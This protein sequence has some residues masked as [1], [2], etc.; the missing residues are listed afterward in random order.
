MEHAMPET[1]SKFTA[2]TIDLRGDGRILLYPR[3]AKGTYQARI[4]VPNSTGFVIKTTKTNRLH[5]ATAF[6]VSLY[7]ELYHHVK[8]GGALK[9]SPTYKAVYEEWILYEKRRGITDTVNRYS[10]PFFAKDPIDR[11]NEARLTD[12]W[13]HRRSTFL[14]RRASNNTLLRECT[15]MNGLFRY[16]KAK[17]YI[18]FIPELN[19]LEIAPEKTRRPT[20]TEREWRII[21]RHMREW[22]KLLTSK[23]V[24]H[25]PVHIRDRVIAINYFLIL[26][27][28]GIRVGEAR[29]LRW[30]DVRTSKD[31]F[32][33]IVVKGKT[34]EREVVAQKGT[35]T[36]FDRI[37]QYTGNQD[38]VF[39]HP[40]GEPIGSL[41]KAFASLLESAKVPK[42]ARTIY[43]LRHLYATFR[44]QHG[45]NPYLLAKN[46][47]TSVEMIEKHY[48]HIINSDMAE[49]ITKLR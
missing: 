31:G 18:T 23:T 41:K 26:A 2:Q 34:G 42:G 46:M 11:I 15:Y 28:T 38:L 48:G 10:V 30:R 7:D 13:L 20:F 39:C 40:D 47:G 49:Q 6:A 21:T 44:L 37:K 32:T 14:K 27:N 17:G 43:S 25:N 22:L 35:A 33:I 36:Y 3:G 4:K 1:V 5:E 12:F 24:H 9:S 19:P 45:T 29:T 8:Q 16:A